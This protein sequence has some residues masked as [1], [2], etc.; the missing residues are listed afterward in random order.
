MRFTIL[1]PLAAASLLL[2]SVVALADVDNTMA[3]DWGGFYTGAVADANFGNTHFALP[4][5]PHDVLL[6]TSS[7]HTSV[8]GGGLVG[9]N[10]QTGTTVYGIEGDLTS[11]DGRSSVTACT[12]VDGCFTPAHDSFT[13]LNHRKTDLTGR[14]RA[15]VGWVSGG[16]LFFAAGG[17]SYADTKLSLV[18][19]CFNAANPPVPLVFNFARSK[20]LSGFNLGVGAERPISEHFVL[21]AEYVFEDFGSQTYKGDGVEW[22]DRSISVRNNTLRVAVAYRF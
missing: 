5:D 22:N 19:L 11:G 18:G 13:T 1:L 16:T 15:R 7:S 14:L 2:S 9:F 6:Q 10:W 3:P 17:Y 21:R 20:S 4:N 12:A 8:G